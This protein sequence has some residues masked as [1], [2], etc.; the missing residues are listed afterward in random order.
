[1]ELS[2]LSEYFLKI[3]EGKFCKYCGQEIT[4]DYS[5]RDYANPHSTATP[6]NLDGEY[7]TCAAKEAIKGY[8]KRD[9]LIDTQVDE[10]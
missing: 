4:L 2:E 8:F 6:R 5:S 10:V 7:H 9:N 3:L 1:M